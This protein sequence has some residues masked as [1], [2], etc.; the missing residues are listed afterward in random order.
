MKLEFSWIHKNWTCKS[1][2]TQNIKLWFVFLLS[3]ACGQFQRKFYVGIVP[4]SLKGTRAQPWDMQKLVRDIPFTNIVI[5]Q[6]NF[7][8]V[9]LFIILMQI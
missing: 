2:W 7:D 4:P 8:K 1:K 6:N 5:F 3:L 9:I